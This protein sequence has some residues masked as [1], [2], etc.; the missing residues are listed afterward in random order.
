MTPYHFT[1]GVKLYV[2]EFDVNPA[3]EFLARGSVAA[4]QEPPGEEREAN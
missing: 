2:A 1:E 3:D 4:A